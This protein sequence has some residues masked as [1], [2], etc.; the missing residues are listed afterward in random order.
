MYVVNYVSIY[1]FD[2]LFKAY[3]IVSQIITS[4]GPKDPGLNLVLQP[5]RYM[6]P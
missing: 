2:Y 3:H 4:I 5:F 6:F 1:L